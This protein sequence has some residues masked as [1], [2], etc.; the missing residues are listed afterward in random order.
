[1]VCEWLTAMI[2]EA[3]RLLKSFAAW[4]ADVG[5]KPLSMA[6]PAEDAT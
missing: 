5:V 4:E 2:F 3:C 1:M 6:E